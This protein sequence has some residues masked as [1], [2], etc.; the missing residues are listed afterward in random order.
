LDGGGTL[1]VHPDPWQHGG[2]EARMAERMRIS[3]AG[4]LGV[5]VDGAVAD[6]AGLGPLAGLA[7]AFLVSERHRPVPRDELAEVLWGEALP[8][9][10]E[11]SLRGVVSRVRRRLE[12]MGLPADVITGARGCYEVHFP[13]IA[14]VDVEEAA[15]GVEAARQ[16]LIDGDWLRARQLAGGAAEVAGRGFLPGLGG[17]WVE[18]RQADL[19]EVHAGAL[20]VLADAAGAAGDHAAALAAAEAAVAA[21]PLRESS[22]LRVMEAHARAGNPAAALRAYERCRVILA[23]ELG[24]SPSERTQAAYLTLLAG[25]SGAPPT[26]LRPELSSFVGRDEARRDVEKLLAGSRLV[27]LVGPGGVGKTRLATRV[28]GEMVGR[29]PDGVWLVELASLAD[30]ALLA[31]HVLAALGAPEKA[32]APALDLLR[33]HVAERQLLV[34]LDNCEHLS[35]ACAGLVRDLLGVAPGLVVLATS[36]EPLGVPGESLWPV[37]P[38]T[39]PPPGDRD[40]RASEAVRLFV[41]RATAVDPHFSLAGDTG[42][43][44]AEICRRLDGVPLAIELAAARVRTMSVLEITDRLRDRFR[45][46]VGRD[47][48]APDRHHTLRAAIDWSYE[49]LSPAEQALFRTISVFAGGFTLDAA[50]AVG[51]GPEV[52]D[53]LATLVDKSLV[54]ADRSGPATRY[55]LLETL[56]QYGAERLAA[57]GERTAVRARHLAWACTLA[58]EAGARLDGPEQGQ[59]LER[60][61]AEEDNLRVALDWA[62]DHP[63]GDHGLRAA[64]ALWQFWQVRGHHEEGGRRLRMLLDASQDAAPALRAKALTSAAVLCLSVHPMPQAVADDVRCLFEEAMAIRRALGDQR[65]VASV[66][67]GLGGLHFRRDEPDAARACFEETLAIGRELGDTQLVAG[68]LNNLA[69]LALSADNHGRPPPEGLDVWALYEESVRLWRELGDDLRAAGAM[70]DLAVIATRTGRF[71][72]AERLLTEGAEIYRRL[73]LRRGFANYTTGLANLARRQADY[74]GA[75]FTLEGLLHLGRDAGDRMLEARSLVEL[76]DLRWVEGERSDAERLYEEAAAIGRTLDRCWP[77]YEALHGLGQVAL[78]RGEVGRARELFAEAAAAAQREEPGMPDPWTFASL[79][80]AAVADAQPAEA[81]A[82]CRKVVAIFAADP[83]RPGPLAVALDVLTILDAQAGAFDRAAMFVG[84]ADAMRARSTPN[85]LMPFRPLPEYERAR[86]AAC[87]GLGD[88]GFE[89]AAA[90]GAALAFDDV[91]ALAEAALE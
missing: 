7:L 70:G 11:P 58:E 83:T 61:R 35:A 40:L 90:A 62:T 64:G 91:M 15:A 29:H 1:V 14:V 69:N 78:L 44:V 26:N 13:S 81:A 5:E 8:A 65:G 46:L 59:W 72:D 22:H 21:Q 24:A 17:L 10:W 6:G 37:P 52:L 36:R 23:E 54:L 3:L 27:T 87:E 86:A 66:L 16:A 20:E 80:N 34:V 47:P 53:D 33:T 76:A 60:L 32:G 57:A 4:Q 55:R 79:A 2:I 43:A 30:A 39:L 77:L 73:G 89:S 63:S 25:E 82:L 31:Q 67:H 38:L 28:A 49:A 71:E 68:S 74:D 85:S 12:G 45:L 51:D 48:T 84:A 75:R 19:E 41:E 56:R 88:A 50:E 42:A 9:T 18:R